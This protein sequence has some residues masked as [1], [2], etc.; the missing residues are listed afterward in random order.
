[1]AAAASA[2]RSRAAQWTVGV[3]AATGVLAFLLA[4]ATMWLLVTDPVAASAAV[5]IGDTEVL[6]RIIGKA[7]LEIVR[8]VVAYF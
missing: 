8:A 4:S 7:L 6:L 5:S 2:A 3:T 1:M